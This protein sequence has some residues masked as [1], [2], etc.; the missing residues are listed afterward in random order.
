MEQNKKEKINRKL[1]QKLFSPKSGFSVSSDSSKI[2]S[3]SKFKPKSPRSDLGGKLKNFTI[4]QKLKSIIIPRPWNYD[5][6]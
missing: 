2:I 5:T 4:F 1:I 6:F 3:Y